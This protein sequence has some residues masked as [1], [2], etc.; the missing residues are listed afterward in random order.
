VRRPLDLRARLPAAS[1]VAPWS[2]TDN[3]A[4]LVLAMLLAVLF[5]ATV[6]RG[7]AQVNDTR[8][9]AVASWS[10]ATTG[11]PALP[12]GWPASR[13]YWGV[14]GRDGQVYVNRFPG[15]AYIATPAYLLDRA[16]TGGDRPAHPLLVDPAP[17]RRTAALLAAAAAAALFALFRQVADRRI[18]LLGAGTVALGTS[19]WSVAASAPWPH[20]PA[21]LAIAACLWGWRSDRPVVAAVCGALAVT[22]RPHIV[23]ALVLLAVFA[24][25]QQ[26]WRPATALAG[27]GC[28]GLLAVGV[29]S[30]WAFGTWLPIA[31]YDATAHLGALVSRSPWWTLTELGAALVAPERGL[32]LASPW[33]AVALIALIFRWRH[34]PAWTRMAA[35]AGVAVLI[36]QLRVAGHAGGDQLA[37]Y[38]VSLEALT[39]AAPALVAAASTARR[40]RRY[41]TLVA[42]AIAS[43]VVVHT[44]AALNGG[45]DPTTTARWEQLDTDLR[46][47]FGHLDVGQA[48]LTRR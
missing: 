25:R 6:D 13:N 3:L 34:L 47:R 4:V 20:A 31:G 46:D 42:V 28:V 29:Y 48:D 23:V 30:A 24:W 9:I 19:L 11:S 16:I 14:T 40:T 45:I 2:R 8:A 12:E 1:S 10:L 33:V 44:S 22:V 7:P 17:A 21:M 37:S 26:G 27:G 39:F 36:V 32:L 38:R 15:I 35:L 18:A 5:L 41:T 43:S